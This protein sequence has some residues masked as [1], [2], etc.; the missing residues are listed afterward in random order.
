MGQ[1][2]RPALDVLVQNTPVC[3]GFSPMVQGQREFV[4]E[5]ALVLSKSGHHHCHCQLL[6][7]GSSLG[8]TEGSAALA[9][10]AE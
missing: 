9:N 8:A 6:K 5:E 4:W 3:S 1:T 7:L 2:A 10:L